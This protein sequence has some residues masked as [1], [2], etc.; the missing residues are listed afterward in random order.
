MQPKRP[1][2]LTTPS[3]LSLTTPHLPRSARNSYLKTSRPKPLQT[4]SEWENVRR[5]AQP[6]NDVPEVKVDSSKLPFDE[7]EGEQVLHFYWLDAYE[8]PFGHKAGSIYLFGKVRLYERAG[9]A[10]LEDHV[11]SSHG[12][13]FGP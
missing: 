6:V 1:L 2:L 11:V 5:E 3:S 7:Y 13:S 10:K 4:P 12:L 9:R 8:P